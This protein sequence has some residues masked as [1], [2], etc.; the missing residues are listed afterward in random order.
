VRPADFIIIFRSRGLLATNTSQHPKNR[1]S[2]TY[3]ALY[4]DLTKGS[5]KDKTGLTGVGDNGRGSEESP[6][7]RRR[8]GRE[9]GDG[10]GEERHR[11]RWMRPVGL[12]NANG[13]W[14][15][16]R[17]RGNEMGWLMAHVSS[18]KLACFI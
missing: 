8:G 7:A 16:R 11:R 4:S 2:P 13:T 6:G 18:L 17:R 9:E 12:L 5:G 10:R 15:S 3:G 1:A 14:I